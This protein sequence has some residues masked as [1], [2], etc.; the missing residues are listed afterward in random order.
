MTHDLIDNATEQIQSYDMLVGVGINFDSNL[1]RLVEVFTFWILFCS[2]AIWWVQ[3][4]KTSFV[5]P[6]DLGSLR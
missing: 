3:V 4:Y 1:Y 6:V 2:F 5:V